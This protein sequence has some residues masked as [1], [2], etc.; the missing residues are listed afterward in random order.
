MGL[1]DLLQKAWDYNPLAQAEEQFKDGG[2]SR[3]LKQKP[4]LNYLSRLVAKTFLDINILC[5]TQL[6]STQYM[7]LLCNPTVPAEYTSSCTACLELIAINAQ[8][9]NNIQTEQWNKGAPLVVSKPINTQ[10][11]EYIE[12]IL[13]CQ[14]SC[15]SC[16]FSNNSQ[17]ASIKVAQTCV[18]GNKFEQE[19]IDSVNATVSNDLYQKNDVLNALSKTLGVPTQN[20]VVS[21]YTSFIDKDIRQMFTQ[22]I[23]S[24]LNIDQTININSTGSFLFTGVTQSYAIDQIAQAL[25][26][27]NFGSTLTSSVNFDEVS[28]QYVDNSTLN[29][30]G[31]LYVQYVNSFA[32]IINTVVGGL[33]FAILALLGTLTLILVGLFIYKGLKGTM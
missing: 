24:K 14:Q 29:N 10:F 32:S 13:S 27:A 1:F 17:Y 26:N 9:Y 5:V 19:I 6:E 28:K 8:L 3:Y 15:K 21:T 16:V 7:K 31:D 30:I 25:L 20:E 18:D 33:M 11:D 22:G 23:F 2:T 12:Q 4:T